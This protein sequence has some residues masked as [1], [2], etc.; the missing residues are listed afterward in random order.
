M[1]KS[2]IVMCVY[3]DNFHIKPCILKGYSLESRESITQTYV[4]KYKDIR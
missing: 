2:L 4:K 3:E 1:V